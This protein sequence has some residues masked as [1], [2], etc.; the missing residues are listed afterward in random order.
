MA[1]PGPNDIAPY[2]QRVTNINDVEVGDLVLVTPMPPVGGIPVPG[3]SLGG[4][5]IMRVTGKVEN[6]R[7]SPGLKFA[8]FP[9]K[10]NP[11]NS[12]FLRFEVYKRPAGPAAAG[13]GPAGGK[14][15]KTKKASR[16][17]RTTR[18]R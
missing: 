1:E 5:K 17:R 8:A 18:R 15:R 6:M 7:G 16:R 3:I 13:A 11:K 9:V 4:P 2:S 12:D 14:R 10:L